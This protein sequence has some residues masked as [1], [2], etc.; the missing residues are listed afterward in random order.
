MIKW[1]EYFIFQVK[2]HN[3]M[4]IIRKQKILQSKLMTTLYD[5]ALVIRIYLFFEA[6]Q[7]GFSVL[8][9]LRTI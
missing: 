7:S 1:F 5:L 9:W 4:F 6:I 2:C 3:A 8:L